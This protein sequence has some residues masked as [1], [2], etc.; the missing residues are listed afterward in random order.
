MKRVLALVMTMLAV[1]VS[2]SKEPEPSPVVPE[3]DKLSIPMGVIK[4][5]TVGSAAVDSR[6]EYRKAFATISYNDDKQTSVPC[7]IKGRGNSSWWNADKKSYRLRFDEKIK[8]LGRHANR[9][10]CLIAN[11]FDKTMIRNELAFHMSRI[12]R[13]E[14][15]PA[16]DFVTVYLNNDYLGVYMLADKI[17]TAKD[18]VNADF[19]MEVD[20]RAEES[21]PQ[22]KVPNLGNPIVVRDPGDIAST[23]DTFKSLKDFVYLADKTLYSDNYC[24][25]EGGYLD[26]IDMASFVDWYLINE[27]SRN[28]DAIMHT[29]CYM[30]YSTGGKLIMGPVWDFDIAF[31]NV[32]YNDNDKTEGFW[33]AKAGWFS[34]MLTDPA[35]TDEVKARFNYYY[36]K[37]QELYDY[38]DAYAEYLKPYVAKNE[39]R[40]HTMDRMLWANVEVFNTY[41][42]YVSSLKKWLESRFQWMYNQ[43]N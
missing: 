36:S 7:E 34:R 6:D 38:I 43:Y 32:N 1:L 13:L 31:G 10:W 12:S 20:N 39:E 15:T 17:E 21:E 29:S 37:R 16:T 22:F 28:N 26:Y 35:F 3:L 42:E 25:L 33:I 40:W 24:A 5:Y 19:L 18:R 11:Y 14:Y 41:E 2:C 4:I 30:H 8:L 27:I 9:D 23:P